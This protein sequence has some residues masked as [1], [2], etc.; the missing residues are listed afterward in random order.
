MPTLVALPRYQM[1]VA[2]SEQI[3]GVFTVGYSVVGSADDHLGSEY[4]E[5]P[6]TGQYDDLSQSVLQLS[7]QRGRSADLTEVEAT[8]GEIT[9]LDDGSLYNPH[10]L[11][12]PL[13][14]QLNPLR[15]YRVQA[16]GPRLVQMT[17]NGWQIDDLTRARAIV[18]DTFERALLRKRPLAYWR[19][20]EAAS[21]S[22]DYHDAGDDPDVLAYPQGVALADADT[23]LAGDP[24]KAKTFASGSYLTVEDG[25]SVNPRAAM[26][27]VALLSLPSLTPPLP[28]RY[29]LHKPGQWSFR[30]DTAGHPSFAYRGNDD[31]LTDIRS[32][33]A[34][35][36][37]TPYLVVCSWDG[38]DLRMWLNG[39]EVETESVPK[40]VWSV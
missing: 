27:I 13:Y 14:G 40:P 30:I 22:I 29:I 35:A 24:G 18:S 33:S 7:Y 3:P 15:P 4:P 25:D 21:S 36:F 10:N 6:Y 39:T 20:D 8:S 34:L 32:V 12:S 17:A 23:L 19:F 9:I 37:A 5:F 16:V 11:D 1:A 26:T 31:A 38:K 28:E 2:W